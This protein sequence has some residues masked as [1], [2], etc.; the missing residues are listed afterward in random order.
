MTLS[1]PFTAAATSSG[2]V[3]SAAAKVSLGRQ[4][5]RRR[6]VAQHEPG[7]ERRQQRPDHSAD[8]ARGAGEY[9]AA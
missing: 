7:I 3:R 5:L 1:A 9:D 6:L 8:A 4:I 2:L